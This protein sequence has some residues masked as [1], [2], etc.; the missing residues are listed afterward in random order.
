MPRKAKHNQEWKDIPGFEGYQASNLGSIRSVDRVTNHG[1]NRK[2]VV[3]SPGIGSAGYYQVKLGK[4]GTQYVHKLVALA[5]I[6]TRPQGQE[7]KHGTEGQL[8]NTIHNLSYGCHSSNLFD[9]RRDNTHGGKSVRRSDGR[10]FPSIAIA[11]EFSRCQA[12]GIVAVCKG[13]RNTCGGWGWS[14]A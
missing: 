5:W 3:L 4:K 14:Y 11:S 7:V 8:V 13:R 10:T 1:H 2:G 6:G 9:K 12:T